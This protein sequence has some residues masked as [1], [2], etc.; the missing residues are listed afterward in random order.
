MRPTLGGN[1]NMNSVEC[2][3][4]KVYGSMCTH[5]RVY[6]CVFVRAWMHVC[7]CTGGRRLTSPL[8]S[9]LCYTVQIK[10]A[11]S[12]IIHI[13]HTYIHFL[14]RFPPQ[15]EISPKTFKCFIKSCE[16]KIQDQITFRWPLLDCFTNILGIPQV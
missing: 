3:C 8:V 1:K 12:F 9:L 6:V 5:A 13:V 11:F 15:Y 4:T 2:T 7:V 10:L 14:K 16:S